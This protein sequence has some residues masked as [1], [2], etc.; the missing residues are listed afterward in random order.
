MGQLDGKTAVVTGG[1]SGI[2]LAVAECYAAEGAHVV[3]AGRNK[4]RLDEAVSQIQ[5]GAVGVVTDVADEQQVRA[6]FEDLEQV[7][8]LATFAGSATFGPIDEFAPSGWRD[9]FGSRFFGQV[10][11]CHCA[12]PKMRE[13]GVILLCSGIAADAHV[14]NYP[15]GSAICGAVNGMGKSLA[16]DLA[17]RG[18]R[19]NVLS[20]GCIFGTAIVTNLDNDGVVEFV[21]AALASTP[22]GRPGEPSHLADAA[23][24]LTTNDFV[25]GHILHVDGGWTAT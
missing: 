15:A 21:D 18:I 11:C 9:Y 5:H 3:I 24:F 20:P 22:L 1:G 19:V 4:E 10:Y 6:L 2:G 7:D 16:V 17:P 8:I 14:S 25:N 23:M 12:V 13:G